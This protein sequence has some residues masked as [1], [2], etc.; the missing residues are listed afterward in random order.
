MKVVVDVER[1]NSALHGEDDQ[2]I[3][4]RLDLCVARGR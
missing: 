1:L 3:M 2:R 4:G